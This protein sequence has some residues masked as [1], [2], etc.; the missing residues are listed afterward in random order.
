MTDAEIEAEI[1]A[2]FPPDLRAEI[3]GRL[4]VEGREADAAL[5]RR[6]AELQAREAELKRREQRVAELER[7]LAEQQARLSAA[8]RPAQ[9]R[10]TLEVAEAPEQ[11]GEPLQ[12]SRSS[13][14][15]ASNRTLG[16]GATGAAGRGADLSSGSSQLEP[17]PVPVNQTTPRSS[18]PPPMGP[19]FEPRTYPTLS[20]LP[21]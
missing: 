19:R 11:S 6:F 3:A 16:S 18:A 4:G 13:R 20:K 2:Y 17:P 5:E 9:R 12:R 8:Q 21:A 1:M 14:R 15:R 10:E 7:Q